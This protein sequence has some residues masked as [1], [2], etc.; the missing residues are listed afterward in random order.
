M[1]RPQVM[2]LFFV[3][4]RFRRGMVCTGLVI[5]VACG[6]PV[7]CDGPSTSPPGGVPRGPGAIVLAQ[8]PPYPPS[9][10]IAHV[11]WDFGSMVRHAPGSDLWPVTW[12]GDDRLYTAWGDGGGFGGTNRDGRVS[13]GVARITGP[14]ERCIGENVFGGKNGA[15]PASF[16]GKSNGILSV[17]GVLYLGVVEQGK[18]RRW[19]IGRSTDYGKS[20]TF[21]SRSGWDFAEPDGAF[22]DGT[23]LTFGRDYQGARDEYV[24]IYSQEDR[25]T[26]PYGGTPKTIGMFRVTK[27]QLTSRQAYEYFAGLDPAGHPVWT[28]DI[29]RRRP[30][31]TNPDGVGW[32]TRVCY[33]PGLGRYLLTSWHTQASGW[34]IFDAPEPWGPWTTVAYYDTWLD[35]TF[36]FGFTF[37][38]KWMS[39]DGQTVWMIFSG[40]KEYDSFNLIRASFTLRDPEGRW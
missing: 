2:Q 6:L 38:Q 28:R 19:K 1:R 13:L 33:N 8:R 34:G 27:D 23:F 30:V 20:W 29:T 31:F 21:N 40:L 36:K 22:S 16:A 5:A 14:P 26:D 24:Y 10:V 11:T 4:R 7:G 18:W 12:A 37:T 32:G 35:S 39:G 15:A 17:N 3:R 9:P 25:A